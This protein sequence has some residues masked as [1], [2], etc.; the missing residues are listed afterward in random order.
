MRLF[1]K[2]FRILDR[3]DQNINYIEILRKKTGREKSLRKY[4]NVI[5]LRNTYEQRCSS[6]IASMRGNTVSSYENVLMESEM[7]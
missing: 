3:K 7:T 5:S 1:F 6:L 4:D 2:T